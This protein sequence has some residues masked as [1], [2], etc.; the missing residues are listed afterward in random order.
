MCAVFVIY[1][2]IFGAL[3]RTPSHRIRPT[4]LK[5]CRLYV[6]LQ[7]SNY[8]TSGKTTTEVKLIRKKK[9]GIVHLGTTS[10]VNG[11]RFFVSIAII[12]PYLSGKR[13]ESKQSDTLRFVGK[14]LSD[15]LNLG[16]EG[17]GFRNQVNSLQQQIHGWPAADRTRAS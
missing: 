2:F 16:G 4:G 5:L 12:G 3:P 15:I 7:C 14:C 8:W 17:K 13:T 10:L 9:N 11:F 6:S 1:L